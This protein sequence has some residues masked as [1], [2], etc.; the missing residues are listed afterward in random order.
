MQTPATG[1]CMSFALLR[2][3]SI[4]GWLTICLVGRVDAQPGAPESRLIVIQ[5]QLTASDGHWATVRS[6]SGIPF[7]VDLS[8]TRYQDASG[9]PTSRIPL[10]GEPVVVVGEPAAP[11]DT[12]KAKIVGRVEVSIAPAQVDDH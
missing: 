5:G 3:A 6:P 1:F 7:Q 11:P 2:V 8:Q 4:A 10:V 12:L 9:H